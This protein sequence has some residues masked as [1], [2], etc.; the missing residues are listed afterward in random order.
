ME[1]KFIFRTGIK[2]LKTI[3]EQGNTTWTAQQMVTQIQHQIFIYRLSHGVVHIDSFYNIL[4]GN[5]LISLKIIFLVPPYNKN[6]S[7]LLVPDNLSQYLS[8]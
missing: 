7:L 2:P 5:T 6:P 1:G 4:H 3:I 8:P